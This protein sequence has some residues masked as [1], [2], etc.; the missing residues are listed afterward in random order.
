VRKS[1]TEIFDD[2]ISLKN[3]CNKI[4]DNIINAQQ[5]AAIDND[6]YRLIVYN[7]TLGDTLSGLRELI[8]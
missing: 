1:Q 8:S 4:I 3:G 7:I 5:E 6:A 2:F